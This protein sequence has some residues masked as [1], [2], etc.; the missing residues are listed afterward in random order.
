[1]PVLTCPK[2]PTKLKVPDGVSGNTR[3]PKCGTVFPVVKP[4]FEVVENEPAQ[5]PASKA[6]PK[7][8]PP[9]PPPPPKSVPAKPDFEVVEEDEEEDR[10]RKKRRDE[11]DDGRS[12]KKK[13][14]KRYYEDDDF[15]DDW[16]PRSGGGGGGMYGKGKTGALLMGISFWLNLGAYGLLALYSLIA[17]MLINGSSSS[18]SSSSRGGGDGD[19]SFL[20]ILVILPGLIGLGAWI[21]GLVGCSFAIAGPRSARGLAITATVFAGLHLILV[22]VT[23]GTLQEGLGPVGRGLP[24]L[25]KVA[26]IAVAST[27]PV[28]DMFLPMVF[29]QSKAIDG[30]F[31]VALLAGICEAGRLIAMLFA[32]KA[33]ASAARDYDASERSGYGVMIVFGVLGGVAL[34]SLLVVILLREGKFTSLSTVA[35]LSLAT[36]FL[37]Y[38]GYTLMM[39][40]PAMAAMATKDACDRRS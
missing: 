7:I 35:N 4:A 15:E 18:S 17:W 24:G 32:L 28:L 11:D 34:I 26:W 40:S 6:V 21:V 14:K 22:G 12:R 20:D 3:C 9:P 25:G 29:Y 33:L 1:V 36:V 16:Q 38:L 37:M 27:L 8:A 31:V 19:G 23:F 2:C 5:K 10:P 39:L 30:D 13:K